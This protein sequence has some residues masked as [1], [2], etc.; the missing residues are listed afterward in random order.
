[1]IWGCCQTEV[2]STKWENFLFLFLLLPHG[3]VLQL[4]SKHHIAVFSSSKSNC[5]EPWADKVVPGKSSLT[6]IGSSLE[7][8]VCIFVGVD[9]TET[10]TKGIPEV[11]ATP[12]HWCHFT[13][14]LESGIFYP[15][16]G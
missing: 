9:P 4:S 2:L 8:D 1:M 12:L 7:E 10:I 11:A 5:S 15:C 16:A 6:V 13:N 3:S 14:I